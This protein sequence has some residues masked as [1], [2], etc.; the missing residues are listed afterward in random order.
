MSDMRRTELM[1]IHD[2]PRFPAILR[3]LTTDALEALW[4]FGNS[5]WPILG[6]LHESLAASGEVPA[7]VI[8]L[9]SG[10]GGPWIGIA[11]QL[12]EDHG[13]E[14]EVCLTDRYP[15]AEAFTRV[16][17]RAKAAKTRIGSSSLP[18]DAAHVPNELVGFRTMFSSFHHFGPK[19]ALE[20]LSSAVASGQGIGI[21]EVAKRGA[22]TLL[23]VCVTPLLVLWLTPRMRPFRWSRLLWTYA[24]PVIPFVIG[25]DGI[26]SCLRTY[27]TA[28][29]HELVKGF[30][31]YRW[32]I[33]ETRNGFLPVTYVIGEPIQAQD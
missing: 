28:E 17:E 2:H 4:E 22:R 16:S 29:L 13:V 25:Y 5:Y 27:S 30:R 31:G 1:E 9:C 12:R 3:N 24:L 14:V 8:D 7:K 6:V 26:I 20:M 32:R 10:G 19:Q 15:N 33:G 21:F 18:V 23:A 11:R